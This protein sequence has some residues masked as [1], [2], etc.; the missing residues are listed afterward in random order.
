MQLQYRRRLSQ[1]LLVNASYTY[2]RRYE[3]SLET[4]HEPRFYIRD[5][6][7]A[8]HQWKLNWTYDLPFGRGRR[9]GTDM[10]P[11]LNA[12]H[13]RVGA[14]GHEPH[15][16]RAVLGGRRPARR[17]VARRAAGR[18]R[19]PPGDERATGVTTVFM[20][21]QDIIDN[22]R[23]AYSVDPN[24]ATGYSALG[25]PTGRYIAPASN[26]ATAASRSIRATAARR[27][28]SRCADR[29]SSAG[30]SA[31]RRSSSCRAASPWTSAS[32]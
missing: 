22:T 14:V 12:V 13:R 11:V 9:F 27:R 3:S 25:V 10:N 15:A 20:M 21:S 8:P 31:A 6:R 5:D 7:S 26:G 16:V 32:S 28:R 29:S 24:S 19:D 18:V 23:R 1:G 30:T 17:H 4:I 2:A